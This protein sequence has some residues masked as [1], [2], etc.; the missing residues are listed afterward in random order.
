MGVAAWIHLRVRFGHAPYRA[1][2]EEDAVMFDQFIFDLGEGNIGSKV[3]H[4]PLQRPRTA[5]IA[6][7]SPLRKRSDSFVPVPVLYFFHG[8]F[9]KGAVPVKFFLP[10]R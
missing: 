10:S 8:Y 5:A 3:G 6:H 1:R 9:A 7:L 4:D 2:H